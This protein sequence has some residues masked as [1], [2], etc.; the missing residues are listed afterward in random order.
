VVLRFRCVR[1]VSG[2]GCEAPS[3]GRVAAWSDGRV[4][5]EAQGL[6][7]VALKSAARNERVF[8]CDVGVAATRG[9]KADALSL[10]VCASREF[11]FAHSLVELTVLRN[12][13]AL[14]DAVAAAFESEAVRGVAT[15]PA[16]RSAKSPPASRLLAKLGR[17]RRVADPSR[18]AVSARWPLS[19]EQVAWLL[20][21]ADAYR[22]R[23]QRSHA[24]S[25]SSLSADAADFEEARRALRAAAGHEG[26]SLA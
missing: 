4:A 19:E 10:S 5:A 13:R 23:A 21:E 14:L 26:A 12:E 18:P 7:S 24:L 3:L 25:A 1:S 2:A 20:D 22:A 15:S 6:Q 9:C 11:L 8:L 17:A 16:R